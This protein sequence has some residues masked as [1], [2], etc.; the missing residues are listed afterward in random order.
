MTKEK[1]KNQKKKKNFSGFKGYF[2]SMRVQFNRGTH[3][4][5]L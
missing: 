3:L 2:R 5:M 4:T 1:K